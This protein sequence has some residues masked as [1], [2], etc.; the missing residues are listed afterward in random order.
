MMDIPPTEAFG[1]A[2]HGM[3]G[4]TAEL[5]EAGVGIWGPVQKWGG[6]VAEW[7]H[8]GRGR[9]PAGV[10]EGEGAGKGEGF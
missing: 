10:S 3:G 7:P 8:G 9:D 4:G 6:A 5:P 2:C 1:F